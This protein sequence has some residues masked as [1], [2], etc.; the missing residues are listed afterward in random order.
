MASMKIDNLVQ[1]VN[2]NIDFFKKNNIRLCK[3][4]EKLKAEQQKEFVSRIRELH[5]SDIEKRSCIF[6]LKD[7]VKK[8]IDIQGIPEELKYV[9]QIKREN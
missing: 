6:V 5:L 8:D 9:M 1:L 2:N 3:T 4:V 7:E